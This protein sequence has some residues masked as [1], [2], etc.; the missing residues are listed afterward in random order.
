MTTNRFQ[1][2]DKVR[3]GIFTADIGLTPNRV[4]TVHHVDDFGQV[5]P[6]SARHHHY[7]PSHFELVMRKVWDAAATYSLKDGEGDWWFL[8]MGPNAVPLWRMVDRTDVV[9]DAEDGIEEIARD[10]GIDGTPTAPETYCLKDEDGDWWVSEDGETFRW[11]C[12]C[13]G[14]AGGA[15]SLVS[16]LLRGINVEPIPAMKGMEPTHAEVDEVQSWPDRIAAYVEDQ[17][18]AAWD[19]VARHPVFNSCYEEER[20]LIDAMM[21][22]LDRIYSEGASPAVSTGNSTGPHLHF[23]APAFQ[24][25]D[26]V[27]YI[28]GGKVQ[29]ERLVGQIGT[30][31]E[32]GDQ[33]DDIR[34]D[35]DDRDAKP[36]GILAENLR[37]VTANDLAP[38]QPGDWV[39]VLARVEQVYDN[40]SVRAATFQSDGARNGGA[41]FAIASAITRTDEVPEWAKET[42]PEEPTGLGAVVRVRHDVYEWARA[43]LVDGAETLR[44]YLTDSSGNGGWRNW[45]DLDVEEVLSEGVEVTE[46]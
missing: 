2:G 37:K 14:T 24:V 38:L 18:I 36:R 23:E 45:E 26:H 17:R 41:V 39:K 11:V 44:W 35:W 16:D 4:Y 20:P 21:A 6:D 29:T 13:H 22:K 40:D 5:Q 46:R 9:Y 1:P 42:K 30:V 19:R 43:V 3:A 34:V 25:G 12:E 33:A 7:H 27:E 8:D 10:Y 32:I 15:T 31:A 28:G